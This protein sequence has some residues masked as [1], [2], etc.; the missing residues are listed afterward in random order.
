MRL[1]EVC[2]LTNDVVK[3]ADFYKALMETDNGSQDEVHQT[4]ISEETMLTIYNDGSVKNNDN[5]NMC[6]AFTTDDMEKEYEKVSALGAEIIEK[7]TKRPWG[8]VNMSFY[9]PDR[10]IVYLREFPVNIISME[11][12]EKKVLRLF[13]EH[14]DFMIDFLGEDQ[15]YYTR[16]SENEKIEKVWVAVFDDLPIGCIAY[17]KKAEGTGEVKRLYLKEEYR[18]KGISKELLKTLEGYAR[19]QG[20][21]TLFLDTRITLEPAV[22]LYRAFGFKIIFQQ[23]LY[24]Q[25]EK[26]LC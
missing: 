23:G 4:I 24:I 25:M 26:E 7:P 2:L 12:T 10:N 15:I 13:S 6:I 8:A 20:C 11:V 21:S 17:R 22:S 3:L 18:G 9:D 1:G 14:D 16:Y 5:Q 19:G